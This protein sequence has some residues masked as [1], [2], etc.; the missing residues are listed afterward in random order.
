MHYH[1]RQVATLVWLLV[2]VLPSA[3]LA[4]VPVFVSIFPQRY[5]VEQVG[6]EHVDVQVMVLPGASPTTYEP[7]SRQM[8][9]IAKAKIYFSMG[10]PFEAVWLEKIVASNKSLRV[11]PM[12]RGIQKRAM[13][14]FHSHEEK[15]QHDG[16]R[17]ILHN[18]GE[19]IQHA[20]PDPHVWLSPPL[21]ILQAR[22]ILVALQDIDPENGSAYETNFRTFIL[23]VLE[24]DKELRRLLKPHHGQRFMVFHPAWGYFADTYHLEQIPVE[25]EG[26][27]PKPAQLKALITNAR[28]H[29]IKVLFLQPQASAKIAEQVAKEIGAQVAWADPLA[30]DWAENLRAVAEK[31]R[32]AMESAK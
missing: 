25:M 24:L 9:A 21:V 18:A 27:T 26:K 14:S 4:K 31:F 3:A 23:Q 20:I 28:K 15:E 5:F 1:F 2:C 11:V 12:D 7:K 16:G 17:T 6:G 32:Q 8:A 22:T 19:T 13:A 30:L 10:V 29:R